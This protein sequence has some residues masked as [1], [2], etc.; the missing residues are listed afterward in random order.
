MRWEQAVLYQ[1]TVQ[2]VIDY[3]GTQTPVGRTH[4][5]QL[6]APGGQKAQITDVY[7][8]SPTWAPLIAEAVA[9]AQVDKVWKLVGEG[10]TVAFGPYKISGA[11][12]TNAAGEVLPWRDVNE[13]AVR[14]GIVCV[15]RTGRTKAWAA[16]QAH[17][18]PNLLVFLTIVDNLHRQ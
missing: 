1:Q 15:W 2:E 11:G 10:K 7:A 9:R 14:G 4:N 16:S 18:V 13:V 5:S 8:D 6:V 17:K 12:V 3:K